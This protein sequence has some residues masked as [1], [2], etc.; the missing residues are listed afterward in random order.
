MRRDH[1]EDIGPIGFMRSVASEI[2]I[3]NRE[4]Y[5]WR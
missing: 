1:I 5:I 3:G 4:A 2:K